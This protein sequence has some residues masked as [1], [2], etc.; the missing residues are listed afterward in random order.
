MLTLFAVSTLEGWPNVM[1]K[2]TES[3][4]VDKGPK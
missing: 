3:T 2:A 4:E 1:Y